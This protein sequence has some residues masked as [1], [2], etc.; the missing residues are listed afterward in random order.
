MR[1]QTIAAIWIGGLILAFLLYI[2]GPDRFVEVV[3][4]TLD[5]FDDAFRGLL[6]MLGAQAFNAIRAVTIA[7]YVVFIVLSGLAIHR[8][9]RAWG[10]FIVVS[11]LFA[12][13]VWHPWFQPPAPLGRWVTAL[14][15]CAAGGLVMT[16][17]LLMPPPPP[18][19]PNGPRPGWTPPPGPRP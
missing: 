10:G 19:P 12:V 3:L 9:L 7:L 18:F 6:A 15:L 2:T 1:R 5:A 13:L 17:R 4:N 11:V 14:I 8:G 16:Q